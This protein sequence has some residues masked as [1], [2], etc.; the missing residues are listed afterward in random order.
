MRRSAINLIFGGNTG[1]HAQGDVL[2]GIENLVGSAFGDTLIGDFGDN[3]IDGGAGDDQIVGYDGADAINGGAGSDTVDYFNAAVIVNLAA[4]TGAG[5]DA[6]GD[7][8]QNV[9]NV[10]GSALNDILIGNAGANA[11][12]GDD[13]DDGLTGHG[14][15]D[16]LDGG[17]GIDDGCTTTPR[18]PA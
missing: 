3:A 17:N 6:Q 1:G 8:F 11:L 10:V 16:A 9:E 13:G 2:Q 12:N 7:T 18:Q 4:G 14:G 15:A 5:G